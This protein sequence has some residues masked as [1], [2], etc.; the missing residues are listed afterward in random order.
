MAKYGRPCAVSIPA[1]IQD[2]LAV[3]GLR[4]LREPDLPHGSFA[5]TL[6]KA[7]SANGATGRRSRLIEGAPVGMGRGAGLSG[8]SALLLDGPDATLRL[9]WESRRRVPL[10]RD[11]GTSRPWADVAYWPRPSYDSG[12]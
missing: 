8:M 12:G 2:D 9:V 10:R 3:N 5:N 6:E 1:L 7:V 4:S 11:G